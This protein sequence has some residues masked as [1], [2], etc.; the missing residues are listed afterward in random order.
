METEKAATDDEI[1]KF[2]TGEHADKSES[3]SEEPAEADTEVN[4]DSE[5]YRSLSG[6]FRYFYFHCRVDL[7]EVWPHLEKVADALDKNSRM[8]LMQKKITDFFKPQE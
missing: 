3:D 7:Y 1:I 4:T 5:C 8:G 2:V 6:A